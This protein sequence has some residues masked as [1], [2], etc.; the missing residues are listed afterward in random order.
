ME[1]K[2]FSRVNL[3]TAASPDD[4]EGKRSESIGDRG[5]QRGSSAAGDL[6]RPARKEPGG[7]QPATRQAGYSAP[8]VDLGGNKR[9]YM[10][11]RGGSDDTPSK[12]G[13]IE[14][15]AW[16]E[17][18][19]LAPNVRF[20]RT[21]DYEARKHR[22]QH[23]RVVEH[24]ATRPAEQAVA[25]SMIKGASSAPSLLALPASVKSPASQPLA[26]HATQGPLPPAA[27]FVA[28]GRA[29]E[30]VPAV[31]PMPPRTVAMARASA[32]ASV[33][34]G[35]KTTTS[36]RLRRP[37]LSDHAFFEAMA[38]YLVDVSSPA[39]QTGPASPAPLAVAPVTTTPIDIRPGTD[40][41][42]LFRVIDCLPGQ[43]LKPLP[44][45]WPANSNQAVA[46]PGVPASDAPS[47]VQPVAIPA[48]KSDAVSASAAPIVNVP[49]RAVAA[50]SARL[51]GAGKVVL[52]TAGDPY[53]LPSEE[54][55]QQPPEGQGFYM[56]QERLEQNADLLESVLEDFGVRGEIIHVRPGPVVTL[57]EFEPAP[58]VKSSRVIGLADDIARSMSAI[59][60]RVAVVPGRNVIGIELPNETRETVYFR[61]L[62]ESEGFRKTSCKLALC[63]GKTI[64]G[65][66]VI[67]ELA[68][69]PHLLVAG[70]TGSGKSVAINTMILSLLY[71]LKP[72]ECRLIMVDP[73]MLELS[74]YDGIPHLLTPVVTDP[75]KAV[76]ALKWAVREMEDRYRKMARLGVRNIDGYNDRA[77]QARDKGET[78][79]MTVQTGFE[80]GTGE[81]LFEQQE[82]DLAPMPY[83]VV[84]VDEMADLMMV[85]G[86]EIE[87]AIQRLAQ[88]ARAAGIHL[89]MATQRPSVDVITGTIKAN[90][91]TRISF[92]VTSKI[93]SRTI[94]GE[95]GAE[96][97]LGQGDMLHMMGGGRISRVHGPFVSDAEVEHVV[98][99]LKAQGRP[100]YLETVTADEDEEEIEEDQGAVLDKGSV[101]A[102]DSD[103]IYDEAVKVVVRDKKCS[104]SYIQRRL[105]IGYNRAASLVERMEKEGLVG[106]PNHVGKREIIMGRRQPSAPEDD[107]AD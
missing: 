69:M 17:Y 6:D 13:D 19:F 27:A 47:P 15:P 5:G 96:Q 51:P 8:V 43:A 23:E 77:A 62:I 35:A 40:A 80:K 95:Q 57:Y 49:A 25:Q 79:V 54:L 75:K 2:R 1:A 92:Q 41:T 64:G 24:A 87:G 101:A 103:A 66:P 90:F 78:V 73:K 39:R 31:A 14:S 72:E 21:P 44:D 33:A 36:E 76:T 58:G 12:I 107:G 83:I 74:V 61:E 81:P 85:A 22:P 70:T 37:Y 20:T 91:P 84:I 28:A 46:Q 99:H 60:A 10:E 59:S 38:P 45:A 100:E 98:A 32:R 42:A 53:E 82:I 16:Q 102:E 68:K 9:P 56:S 52:S 7:R 106:A 71:R 18:F 34:P 93:D 105:G 11:P 65:E 94:L 50:R 89:I 63:L 30:K 29:R 86:K 97:L 88:M 67:A 3:S 48:A 55:L 4:P 104:T 26:G